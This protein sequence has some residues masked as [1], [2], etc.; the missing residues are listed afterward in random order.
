[1]GTVITLKS[2]SNIQYNISGVSTKKNFWKEYHDTGGWTLEISEDSLQQIIKS[3]EFTV[4][5]TFYEFFTK[6]SEKFRVWRESVGIDD[7]DPVS[8]ASAIQ[9]SKKLTKMIDFRWVIGTGTH[10]DWPKFWGTSDPDVNPHP[11]PPPSFIIDWFSQIKDFT[12][13]ADFP[14]A[15]SIN[16]AETHGDLDGYSFRYEASF[17]IDEANFRET[18][19]KLL[20]DLPPVLEGAAPETDPAKPPWHPLPFPSQP[21]KNYTWTPASIADS[22]SKNKGF[23]WYKKMD[24]CA[25]M[26]CRL[27]TFTTYYVGLG[28]N[29]PGPYIK[30][31]RWDSKLD[32][33]PHPKAPQ[34]G[35]DIIQ[36]REYQ[37]N[38][39][40]YERVKR[41]PNI[42]I[43]SVLQDIPLPK[44]G[45]WGLRRWQTRLVQIRRYPLAWLEKDPNL[46][47]PDPGLLGEDFW[48]V[49]VVRLLPSPGYLEQRAD[50]VEKVVKFFR[51]NL[52][53][54]GLNTRAALMEKISLLDPKPPPTEAPISNDIAF[55]P[56]PPPGAMATAAANVA[57]RYQTER[58]PDSFGVY[59]DPRDGRRHVFVAVS[60]AFID[61]IPFEGD[62]SKAK[63]HDHKQYC[64]EHGGCFNTFFDLGAS[65]FSTTMKKI[66][67][68][69]RRYD[70]KVKDFERRGGV[71]HHLDLAHEARQLE[72]LNDIVD[73]FLK[74]PGQGYEP[75][76]FPEGI[77]TPRAYMEFQC[78]QDNMLISQV[79]FGAK[80][81]AL[82]ICHVGLECLRNKISPRTLHLVSLYKE[83]YAYD[84]KKKGNTDE[85]IEFVNGVIYPAV[86]IY[87]NGSG[88]TASD[89]E[90]VQ[91]KEKKD[92]E[93]LD[94]LYQKSIL[95][96]KEYHEQQELE[97]TVAIRKSRT[98]A[99]LAASKERDSDSDPIYE[100][101]WLESEE[102]KTFEDIY[103][104]LFNQVDM[105]H[106]WA[107]ILK[108]LSHLAGI[109]LT[110]E[111]L[112]EYL[113]R[114]LLKA[115]GVDE[116]RLVLSASGAVTM[117]TI[118]GLTTSAF[119][120]T[121][122]E[123]FTG[124]STNSNSVIQQGLHDVEAIASSAAG[125]QSEMQ[126]QVESDYVAD[127][128]GVVIGE[129]VEAG[130][131][132]SPAEYTA[133]QSGVPG[134]D[135][136]NVAEF[137]ADT[138]VVAEDV[139]AFI[140]ELKQFFDF[141]QICTD[142]TQT[143]LDLPGDFLEDPTAVFEDL[144]TPEGSF[145]WQFLMDFVPDLPTIPKFTFPKY[146]KIT[147]SNG[148]L[149]EI[150]EDMLWE[151]T[152]GIVSGL[153][154]GA[155]SELMNA[156]LTEPGPGP[157]VGSGEYGV[158]E[159]RFPAFVSEAAGPALR[160]AYE[161]YDLPTDNSARF[162]KNVARMLTGRELCNLF[163]GVSPQSILMLIRSL[164]ERDY[165]EYLPALSTLPDIRMFFTH[166]GSYIDLD[167]CEEYQEYVPYIEDL[168]EDFDSLA[169]KRAALLSH[170]FSDEEI[171][172]QLKN[173][174][175]G[176]LE[177][178]KDLM[179]LLR[180]DPSELLRNKLPTLRCEDL[181][182]GGVAPSIAR[183][184]KM[185]LD[186]IFGIIKN[187]FR[188][189]ASSIKAII[190]PD[191]ARE[192]A[193]MADMAAVLGSMDEWVAS[194]PDY[195]KYPAP[196]F[197]TDPGLD[198]LG[199]V[200]PGRG[201]MITRQ[202]ESKSFVF[203]DKGRGWKITDD[204]HI[205]GA[206]R[207]KP[208]DAPEF[209]YI[210]GKYV[211][212]HT[213]AVL[214]REDDWWQQWM[215]NWPSGRKRYYAVIL[216]RPLTFQY[217]TDYEEKNV[218]YEKSG[219]TI[220]DFAYEDYVMA[221]CYDKTGRHPG[222]FNEKNGSGLVSLADKQTLKRLMDEQGTYQIAGSPLP[223]GYP[224]SP[225]DF[226]EGG[227]TDDDGYKNWC[228][229]H[230]RGHDL[231]PGLPHRSCTTL[232][233]LQEL[234]DR[235]LT[236]EL[237]QQD[238][239]ALMKAEPP[240]KPFQR[241]YDSLSDRS[242]LKRESAPDVRY[243]P[244]HHVPITGEEEVW[245][246]GYWS[247]GE[248]SK[249]DEAEADAMTR[250]ELAI[251]A[252][253]VATSSQSK[254][255]WVPGHYKQP[256][257]WVKGEWIYDDK[258]ST[259]KHILTVP[260]S[261]A[262]SQLLTAVNGPTSTAGS[263]GTDPSHK[264]PT[265]MKPEFFEMIRD[266]DPGAEKAMR[267][268]FS[269]ALTGRPDETYEEV[270]GITS[271]ATSKLMDRVNQSSLEVSYEVIESDI[272]ASGKSSDAFRINVDNSGLK[273]I[274]EL[275]TKDWS[276]ASL[277]AM[278]ASG[279]DITKQPR[280]VADLFGKLTVAQFT[281]RLPWKSNPSSDADPNF[282]VK[283]F[284]LTQQSEEKISAVFANH[285]HPFETE[286]IVHKM[287]ERTLVSPFF[288]VKFIDKFIRKL[289]LTSYSDICEFN[290]G[291]VAERLLGLEPL[292]EQID[293][294]LREVLCRQPL[295][296]SEEDKKIMQQDAMYLEAV[297]G[298][299]DQA[300][301]LEP[302]EEASLDGLL[303][304]RLR[305]SAM[306]ILFEYLPVATTFDVRPAMHKQ[307]FRSLAINRV[308]NQLKSESPEYYELIGAR[309]S[310]ILLDELADGRG[311]TQHPNKSYHKHTYEIDKNG[312]GWAVEIVSP[313]AD[314]QGFGRP[315][316][317]RI[318]NYVLHKP[319]YT[320]GLDDGKNYNHKHELEED[321]KRWPAHKA[322]ERIFERQY[323]VMVATMNRLL[324]DLGHS[325]LR[326]KNYHD[327]V[328]NLIIA[329]F[330]SGLNTNQLYAVGRPAAHQFGIAGPTEHPDYG[331]YINSKSP[332]NNLVEYTNDWNKGAAQ[333]TKNGGALVANHSANAYPSNLFKMSVSNQEKLLRDGGF[334]LQPYLWVQH[335]NAAGDPQ[336]PGQHSKIYN[337]AFNKTYPMPQPT[338][339]LGNPMAI[340]VPDLATLDP[341]IQVFEDK[342][343]PYEK[344]DE[345]GVSSIDF[346]GEVFEK[347]AGPFD[348]LYD[349]VM[350]TP[351]GH[352]RPFGWN[353]AHGH[354]PEVGAHAAKDADKYQEMLQK[355][356]D[357]FDIIYSFDCMRP[358]QGIF[359]Y[360]DDISASR[361]VAVNKITK[362]KSTPWKVLTV[363]VPAP[364]VPPAG[365][366]LDYATL[367]TQTSA[368]LKNLVGFRKLGPA[369][370]FA[371]PNHNA[372]HTIDG[373]PRLVHDVYESY[374][375]DKAS[376]NIGYEFLH[377]DG[378]PLDLHMNED[379]TMDVQTT[380]YGFFPVSNPNYTGIITLEAVHKQ[381]LRYRKA[382]KLSFLESSAVDLYME[383]DD[384]QFKENQIKLEAAVK[385]AEHA[386]YSRLV[387][388]KNKFI[389]LSAMN[390]T[391][392]LGLTGVEAKARAHID[393]H[394]TVGETPMDAGQLYNMSDEYYDFNP[395]YDRLVYNPKYPPGYVMTAEGAKET[396]T[397]GNN[398]VGLESDPLVMVAGGPTVANTDKYVKLHTTSDRR[399]FGWSHVLENANLIMI[400]SAF[401]Q[402][403]DEHGWHNAETHFSEILEQGMAYPRISLEY[404]QGGRG[405]YNYGGMIPSTTEA[406]AYFEEVS[407]WEKQ[408]AGSPLNS[409]STGPDDFH[410]GGNYRP[411][412]KYSFWSGEYDSIT[413]PKT[414]HVNATTLQY[415]KQY[416]ICMKYGLRL[417]YVPPADKYGGGRHQ[418]ETKEHED[419]RAEITKGLS[420]AMDMLYSDAKKAQDAGSVGTKGIMNSFEL[421]MAKQKAFDLNEYR[422]RI[423][424]YETSGGTEDGLEH[425]SLRVHPIP[426]ADALIDVEEIYCTGAPLEFG[427]FRPPDV[428]GRGTLAASYAKAVPELMNQLR[429][430]P[431]YNLLFN[432]IFPYDRLLSFMCLHAGLSNQDLRME[433]RFKA[434]REIILDFVMGLIEEG[435]FELPYSMRPYGSIANYQIG[436]DA[437]STS[438]HNTPWGDIALKM[439]YTTPRLILKGVVTLTDPCVSTAITI[440]DLI[441][442]IVN[443]S[444]MIAEEVRSGIIA[445]VGLVLSELKTQLE[446]AES[447]VGTDDKPGMM[448]IAIDTTELSIDKLQK[449]ANKQQPPDPSVQ[450]ELEQKQQ[451]VAELKA[452]YEKIK[453]TVQGIK[454]GIQSAEDALEEA[455]VEMREAIDEVKK[456]VE[457]ISPFMVP[458]I[459]F[460][461]FPV[462]LPY[463]FLFPP[464][465]FG[466]GVGPPMTLF[467]FIY[468]LLLITEGLFDAF[469][470]EKEELAQELLEGV[471][472]CAHVPTS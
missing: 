236:F 170:G 58:F 205:E 261:E 458:A 51:K 158:L 281:R 285:I 394:M 161:A 468:C 85:W 430:T 373:L 334:I 360:K 3:S 422:D 168:C 38:F 438:S 460:A 36:T 185:V 242:A 49:K 300:L 121:P 453:A 362:S 372:G 443:T 176:N 240:L 279:I 306:Q 117:G 409:H 218:H 228:R 350:E 127:P 83:I 428:G 418:G 162:M 94:E 247:Y 398:P 446:K 437:Q 208:N 100:P 419:Y 445:S 54:A 294:R 66:A 429:K 320:V 55:V 376:P 192:A 301:G 288:S 284:S 71:I 215:D 195:K 379:G 262:Q 223:R 274:D 1:M 44:K 68:I 318:K 392:H 132:M 95:T 62:I 102:W 219:K 115:I 323:S 190:S 391:L 410:A 375:K 196:K 233:P 48:C 456:V 365:T 327:F 332:D 9:Y 465:P 133:A 426:F 60:R 72:S 357:L 370:P 388:L 24:D 34:H 424:Y 338:D 33:I 104:K 234:R 210:D 78:A 304:M 47:I 138:A 23:N 123:I 325:H 319:I 141:K 145:D 74:Y 16:P 134:D 404:G 298:S 91:G 253:E 93:R 116:M 440:N 297:E 21:P 280:S 412:Y 45:Q 5:K 92:K 19:V 167:V 450:F 400:D 172:S 169:G 191:P 70:K 146:K 449:E 344:L 107:Q 229:Y 407:E 299:K 206:Q 469:D 28:P 139:D 142:I 222:G 383:E 119:G 378:E 18:L 436:T 241:L 152:A 111:A 339:T 57:G 103:M 355:V 381:Y 14:F 435:E 341:F 26:L 238:P 455:E 77:K 13:G 220:V 160:E 159:N 444:I 311:I 305:L 275:E 268:A 396:W 333:K 106:V 347:I 61:S 256:A 110:G 227:N 6:D 258:D 40:G 403:A 199:A 402:L 276:Q 184:N 401:G 25:P 411:G 271:K 454:D 193:V 337:T 420:D 226:G 290:D 331:L 163:N 112:C 4:K 105:K 231:E 312:D 352:R 269:L 89:Y 52:E 286:R 214:I 295:L 46:P 175:D 194:A 120:G 22:M 130:T 254:L 364:D 448:E 97:K 125:A 114:E 291:T 73:E 336:T 203:A 385:N 171:E 29:K 10:S 143:M 380:D 144:T 451:E 217:E 186:T 257:H 207:G 76:G 251:E 147:S 267:Q 8:H 39:H 201:P 314:P 151:I 202:K 349:V 317:H 177:K 371:S 27:K 96:E 324:D 361:D 389:R 433:N 30:G 397:G 230:A 263:Y 204:R 140:Q 37:L 173:E 292:R 406:G 56:N 413:V 239:A 447:A 308:M 316:K 53:S 265:T 113:F 128:F 416:F 101:S 307:Y 11:D 156:C 86:K 126:S 472:P 434:T 346:W 136:G 150:Y 174:L 248:L 148:D 63:L 165:Q 64:A 289:F 198:Q 463:G 322:I 423:E 87:P 359:R 211:F 283:D 452:E 197:T 367:E 75:E 82:S 213:P 302:I 309:C 273:L 321:H 187:I 232:I 245:I 235:G 278:E 124:E 356:D 12:I 369:F 399:V 183:A 20:D 303:Q 363:D 260:R 326:I 387:D 272:D 59:I 421:M 353:I 417:M 384:P 345:A 405:S 425:R 287:R 315:H 464:P 354:V 90:A 252:K 249:D 131:G 366:M 431:E 237:P 382:Y 88:M 277:N 351:L 432:H 200:A 310:S 118:D 457:A 266:Y 81:T 31:E 43:P 250:S 335:R 188:K 439:L 466:W 122:E 374:V 153:V 166:V 17:N 330:A 209:L 441:M 180:Q 467:G 264:D 259:V 414:G 67:S 470:Q 461:Q 182:P 181:I 164:I 212:N 69:L 80:T 282:A 129:A 221:F 225:I 427:A 135:S 348:Y 224:T 386:A 296:I 35:L 149:V 293:N 244:G 84:T 7:G 154:E 313:G 459:S 2:P 246:G 41:N 157:S 342:D 99:Y 255:V 415:F 270:S 32:Q 462:N 368:G 471:D 98:Q 243:V 329:P 178:I 155:M 179:S 340:D 15:D 442:T 42:A 65:S 109:P 328:D 393:V 108:C 189:E 358:C 50:G 377:E 395:Q 137:M 216:K 343:R 408:N 390:T 79:S